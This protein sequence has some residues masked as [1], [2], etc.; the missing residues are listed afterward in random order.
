MKGKEKKN[1]QQRIIIK[2]GK[3]KTSA[4][5]SP[6]RTRALG[7]GPMVQGEKGGETPLFRV[8][9]KKKASDSCR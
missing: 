3:K 9:E 1:K 5:H 8:L 6:R 7:T 2:K 4:L